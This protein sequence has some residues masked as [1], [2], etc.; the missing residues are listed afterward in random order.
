MK[1]TSILN[2]LGLS[3]NEADIY[4]SLVELGAGKA[5]DIATLANL[6][7][8]T[9]Y[10]LIDSLIDKGLV[11][12][13][14][15][16]GKT[17]FRAIDPKEA[18]KRLIER[19]KEELIKKESDTN[20]LIK[21]LLPYFGKSNHLP[22]KINIFEGRKAI[23]NMLYTYEPKWT[24]SYL[25]IGEDT[26]WGFQDHTFVEEYKKWHEDS[27]KRPVRIEKICL[28]STK[29][30][31][32]QQKKEKIANREIRLMPGRQDFN[33]SI[34][35]HGEY[36]IIATTRKEPHFALLIND[37]VISNNFRMVFKTMWELTD[38]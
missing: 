24:E 19:E 6:P 4:L 32:K 38:R 29:E 16:D 23:E 7:R 10:G 36:T 34:W 15:T 1:F 27:W 14:T 31:L 17:F 9:A 18:L 26:M 12:R 25:N 37:S 20:E 22:P 30:G 8:S 13:E 33:S 11:S 35:L 2:S 21:Y 28:F 5:A 3:N